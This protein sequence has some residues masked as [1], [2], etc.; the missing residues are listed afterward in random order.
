MRLRFV[1]LVA[2]AA[3]VALGL[4]GAARP[5]AGADVTL[6]NRFVEWR[7]SKPAARTAA[8]T[9]RRTGRRW[10]F[11]GPDFT[12]L[13]PSGPMRSD[14]LRVVDVTRTSRRL[15]VTL[16]Y[17]GITV[18]RDISLFDDVAGFR[19]ETVVR[20]VAPFVLSGAQLARV[21]TSSD[22]SAQRLAFRA[23]ADW[24][25]P[26]W[27]GPATE[28]GD[29]HAGTWRDTSANPNGPGQWLSLSDV[30]PGNLFL[31]TE[32][33]DFPSVRTAYSGGVATPLIDYKRDVVSLG[34]FEEQIHVENPGG[35]AGRVRVLA[36]GGAVTLPPV[37]L[38]FG[39]GDG[40]DTWQFHHYLTGHRLVPYEHSVTFN[41]NGTNTAGVSLG[42]KDGM[43]QRTIEQ[44]APLARRLGVD[45]FILDDGWQATSGDWIA[46]PARFP[47]DPN[48]AKVRATIAPMKLGLWMTPLHFH[49]DSATFRSNPQWVCTPVGDGLA[50]YNAA[51]PSS[52]SNAA[53]IG[54]WSRAAL[55]HVE[56]RIRV[57]VQQWGV[58]YFKFDFIAWLDCL[59]QGDM[60]D[61]HDAFVA[62]LDRLQLSFRDVTFQIDETNDYR[63]FPF[64]S[65]SRGPTWFQNGAPGPARLLH[66]L[67]NL[68][69][70]VPSVAIGQHFLGD[71]SYDTWPVDT[72]MAAALLS[73]IT[74]FSDLRSLPPRVLD[75]AAPWLAF[76]KKFRAALTDG[77]VYP[78]L[79]DPLAGG[80]T[81]L[82][83][84]DP[85]K[86]TGALL[87][88]R[89][90]AAAAS[91]TV[92]LRNVPGGRRFELRAGPT[93]RV[94]GTA[95]SRQLQSGL[96]ITLPT[97]RTAQV[98]V[99]TPAP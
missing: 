73:H 95:T 33:N 17:P 91:T 25:E 47:G 70:Y 54:E 50:L 86:A 83:S 75:A 62:M 72:L 19:I 80:W 37:F 13:T 20:A 84:W 57:A 71:R 92:K 93:G 99:I 85:V 77:V 88:F 82:Q 40:D 38:G 64:E 90:D 2:A 36:P 43:N 78:L 61:L 81:A 22:L 35:P 65:I 60:Y 87:V 12:L 27:P 51:D 11:P 28:V 15:H 7:W 41:S 29:P 1:A 53:G 32:A 26:G 89:Q 31:V 44:V 8:I 96:P 21:N 9:D 4:P 5:A 46:D 23:G 79:A 97:K 6:A 14:K 56:R 58:R 30:G 69:P 98:L 66:N 94:V 67:W 74:F 34:P 45:T 59:G 3:A 48:L 42:A 18:T 49:P 10:G 68:S 16:S 24:R 55:A 63:L 76:Y 52:G 39:A